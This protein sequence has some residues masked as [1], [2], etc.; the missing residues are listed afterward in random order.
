M[1][2]IFF[3]KIGRIF[4]LVSSKNSLF[5]VYRDGIDHILENKNRIFF[6]VFHSQNITHHK[7]KTA[8]FEGEGGSGDR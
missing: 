8:L 5:R 6:G 7:L 2:E 3:I 4:F 1:P